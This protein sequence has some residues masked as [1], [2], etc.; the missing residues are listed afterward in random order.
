MA[1]IIIL[2]QENN[3]KSLLVLGKGLKIPKLRRAR[4]Q[5]PLEPQTRLDFDKRLE[6]KGNQKASDKFETQE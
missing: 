1:V 5:P 2:L 4:R 3:Y 6:Q